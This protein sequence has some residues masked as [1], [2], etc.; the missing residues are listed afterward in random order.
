MT[1]PAGRTALA[2]VAV[3]AAG[4]G[5]SLPKPRPDVGALT[6]SSS[7][8][9][10]ALHDARHTATASTLGPQS[11]HVRWRRK[12]EGDVTPGPVIGIDGTVVAASNAGVLH[13]LD[14]ATGRDRWTFDAHGSYGG[15]L[16]TS[17]AV[18]ADGTVLWPGPH[19][20]LYALDVNGHELW[21]VDVPG[22]PLSPAVGGD[23]RVYVSDQGGDLTA[24][25]V[26]PGADGRVAWR[27]HFDTT[28]YGSA[29]IAPSGLIYVTG[30]R[31]LFA[32]TDRGTRGHVEWTFRTHDTIEVSP[33]AEPN[34]TAV[35]GT[36]NDR[37]YG[38]SVTGK[39]IW[40]FA[41][42]AFTYSSPA[43]TPA[44]DAVFGDHL[45]R[46]DIVDD[47]GNLI[48]AD[49]TDPPSADRGR[50]GIGIWTAP[51]LDARGDAY[52]GTASGHIYGFNAAGS[53]LFDI[54]TGAVVDS[55]P[56][57]A[58]GTLYVGAADGTL[59]AVGDS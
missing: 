58:D 55:Y 13:G 19:D 37:E 49:R 50:S 27:L 14:P 36:N 35:V 54:R 3:I 22:Q 12:L 52:F 46:L 21:T 47:H 43:A 23:G 20:R 48:R 51:A 17:P 57:L 9:P 33:A 5:A 16:S 10:A 6:S 15:D 24:I 26:Q 44:G 31:T 11:G 41:K 40:S 42:D 56:A 29:A 34:G 30:A 28:S 18:L 38:V 59:Y 53:P 2:L 1:R 45:G 4:C 39:E 32:I 25:D 7:V 8:W